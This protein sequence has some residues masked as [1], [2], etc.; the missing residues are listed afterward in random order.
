[1]DKDIESFIN[2]TEKKRAKISDLK[3]ALQATQFDNKFIDTKLPD[4]SNQNIGMTMDKSGR[5]LYTVSKDDK[6]TMTFGDKK[7]LLDYLK[8]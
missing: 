8:E 1:M 5:N 6:N 3:H 4:G 2:M 7:Q